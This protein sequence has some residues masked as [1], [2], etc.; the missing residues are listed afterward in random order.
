[1]KVGKMDTEEKEKIFCYWCNA[2]IE[3]NEKGRAPRFCSSSCR[4]SYNN[5]IKRSERAYKLIKEEI[6]LIEQH[7]QKQGDLGVLS[8]IR[9]DE[10]TASF[11]ANSKRKAVCKKCGQTIMF[12]P[13][14]G[15][16]C[17]FCGESEW[18]YAVEKNKV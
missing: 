17:N 18:R 7:G 8:R 3:R 13:S 5:E 6:S 2:P 15:Q 4:D 9:F 12:W 10:L 1:M 14:T 11:S 16:K